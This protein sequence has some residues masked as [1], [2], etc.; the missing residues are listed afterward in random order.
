MIRLWDAAKAKELRTLKGHDG[1][2][3]S[4][5]FSPN[6]KML[7]SGAKDR[8]VRLWDVESGKEISR[9]RE[10]RGWVFAVAFAPDGQCVASA[11]RDQTIIL[12]DVI[13]ERLLLRLQDFDGA[14]FSVVYSPEGRILAAGSKDH[15]LHFWDLASGK[16]LPS[17]EGHKDNVLSLSFTKDGKILASGCEDGTAFIWDAAA[18]PRWEKPQQDL[19]AKDLDRLWRELAGDDIAASYRAWQ[20]LAA[21]PKQATAF[22][23]A[24]VPKLLSLDEPRLAKL[25]ADLDSD[26]F[27]VR[28]KATE[29]LVGGNE[30]VE[31]ALRKVLKEKTLALEAKR[32]LEQIIDTMGNRP[33]GDERRRCQMALEV[34][35]RIGSADAKQVLK[36]FADGP[37]EAA[38]T[39]EAKAALERAAKRAAARP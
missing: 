5:A 17:A 9:H 4:V 15:K 28:G 8:S 25:V 18:L 7:V 2:V 1:I 21:H 10:H 29:E 32:R 20:L 23:E 24:R 27:A 36:A 3:T 35:E 14:F 26:D 31:K 33:A 16:P 19:D 38:L 12:W 39:L 22:F 11:G 34:L 6:G 37:A 13:A 30:L